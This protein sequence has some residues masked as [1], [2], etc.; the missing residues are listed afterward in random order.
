MYS[1]ELELIAEFVAEFSFAK[2]LPNKIKLAELTAEFFST[3]NRARN[4]IFESYTKIST[5]TIKLGCGTRCQKQGKFI[6]RELR[7]Q[8][9]S[10][11]LHPISGQLTLNKVCMI[12]YKCPKPNH[13]NDSCHIN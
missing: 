12:T 2:N 7:L 5:I 6:K 4:R 9:A 1:P 13:S 11:T 10:S 8:P 3:K